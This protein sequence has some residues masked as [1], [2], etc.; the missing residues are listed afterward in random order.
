MKTPFKR[1]LAALDRSTTADD[2]FAQAI[3]LA[4]Q[5]NSRLTL[6]HCVNLETYEQL[7]F[8][9]D[10]SCGLL[11]ST[12]LQRLQSQHISEVNQTWLWL[13]DYAQQAQAQGVFVEVSCQTGDIANQICSLA[14]RWNANLILVGH[15]GWPSL[16]KRIF[17]DVTHHVISRASCSVMVVRQENSLPHSQLAEVYVDRLRQVNQL[18]QSRWNLHGGTVRPA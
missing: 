9:I 16:K 13:W 8:L 14:Q 3:A 15:S 5:N 10:A 7:N 18:A 4:Q 2:V 12:K 17:G 11:S 1:I 6:T